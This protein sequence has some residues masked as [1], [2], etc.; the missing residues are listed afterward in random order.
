MTALLLSWNEGNRE[1]LGEIV[2]LLYE[3]L[4][5]LAV[6]QMRR[7]HR[8]PLLQPTALV[9]E[10]YLK[11]LEPQRPG[12]RNRLHFFA[13][14][15]SIMR[16]LLIDY[17]RTATAAKRGGGLTMQLEDHQAAAPAV[18]DREQILSLEAAL[19]ALAA[20][21]ARKAQVVELKYYGGLSIEEIAT[22]LQ[23]SRA[24]IERDWTLAKAWL[25]RRLARLEP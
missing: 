6:A 12:V 22:H 2:S 17:A 18:L 14:A 21:D 24:T 9:H 11:M 8:Q 15:A 16:R 20:L 19:E 10:A 7:E 13:I 25:H 5:S 1:A 3:Q 23:V 4:R